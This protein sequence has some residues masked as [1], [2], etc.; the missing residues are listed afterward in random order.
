MRSGPPSSSRSRPRLGADSGHFT[1]RTPSG[2][3]SGRQLVALDCVRVPASF[4]EITTYVVSTDVVVKSTEVGMTHR[5][6]AEVAGIPVTRSGRLTKFGADRHICDVKRIVVEGTFVWEFERHRDGV[7]I[8][9]QHHPGRFWNIPVVGR[10]I[11]TSYSRTD[12]WVLEGLKTKLEMTA[13]RRK[14]ATS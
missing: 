9:I 5:C 7:R 11:A 1:R 10:Q 6:R 13:P 8:T 3:Q 4:Y 2:V 14:G 12:R